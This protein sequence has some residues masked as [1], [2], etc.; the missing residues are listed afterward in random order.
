[1]RTA[2]CVSSLIGV[3]PKTPS[4]PAKP[5]ARATATPR[6]REDRDLYAQHS[7]NYELKLVPARS[8]EPLFFCPET[9]PI[10]LQSVVRESRQSNQRGHWPLETH[11]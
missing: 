6:T 2:T 10:L 1:M 4:F 9:G 3:G 8:K 5:C 11:P 7:L